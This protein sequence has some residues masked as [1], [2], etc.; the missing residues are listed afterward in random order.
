MP[1]VET[2]TPR[3]KPKQARSQ[4]T[5]EALLQAAAQ[6]L[7]QEGI[8][9]ATTNRIAERAGVSV[10]SLYQYF[11]SKEAVIFALVERHVARMQK[12]LE[13][14][15]ARVGDMPI[16]QAVPAYVKAMFD[17]HR[18]EPKLHKVF[19]EQLPKLAGRETFQRWA[20]DAE[21]VVR[22]YLEGH[23]EKLRPKDLDMAAFVLVH[24]VDSLTHAV[25]ILKPRYLERESLADEVSE[26]VLRYLR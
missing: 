15:V 4:A 2:V 21:A 9:A 17:V 23:R 25:V 22:A 13:D 18:V 10:G 11:P 6:I 1:Q 20:D 12:Q 7:V 3:K 8:E 5:M 24:A 16:E 19:S 26:L 14:M